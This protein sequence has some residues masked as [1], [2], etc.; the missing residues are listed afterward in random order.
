MRK[1]TV[2]LAVLGVGG[3]S[4]LLF[5]EAGRRRLGQALAGVHEAPQR[6]NEDAQNELDHLQQTLDELAQSFETAMDSTR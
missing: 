1:W 6:W 4:A 3:F 5:S 2:P